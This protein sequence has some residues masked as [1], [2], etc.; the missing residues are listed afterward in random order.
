MTVDFNRPVQTQAGR[1]VRIVCTDR[2]HPCPI[3]GLVQ[4]LD[5]TESI[6]SWPN[7]GI[8]T[9]GSSVHDLI[10]VPR[11]IERWV[12]VFPNDHRGTATY[13]TEEEAAKYGGRFTLQVKLT[14]EY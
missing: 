14:G 3:V 1:P 10:N 12:N 8:Y 5:G 4:N 6:Y 2:K 9:M 11:I 7:T 13:D